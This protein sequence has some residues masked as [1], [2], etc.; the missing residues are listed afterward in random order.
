MRDISLI[1]LIPDRIPTHIQHLGLE[2]DIEEI[3]GSYEIGGGSCKFES[4]FFLVC[5]L[6]GQD[7]ELVSHFLV[8]S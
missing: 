1:L 8:G 6:F 5:L 7:L 4:E 3:F 2:I